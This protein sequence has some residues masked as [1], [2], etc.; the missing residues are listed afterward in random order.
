AGP[1]G[2]SGACCPSRDTW[3]PSWPAPRMAHWCPASGARRAS[4]TGPRSLPAPPTPQGL[5][6]AGWDTGGAAL[7]TSR[8]TLVEERGNSGSPG[9]PGRWRDRSERGAPA[10][11]EGR[12]GA[13]LLAFATAHGAGI[14]E[15]CAGRGSGTACARAPTCG[16]RGGSRRRGRLPTSLRDQ[17]ISEPTNGRTVPGIG[18]SQ[19]F[20]ARG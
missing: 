11:V 3:R 9:L 4:R 18:W 19:I 13:P 8:D 7:Q 6:G 16:V 20:L 14:R 5:T 17:R 12:P 2:Y 10:A 1:T 15:D